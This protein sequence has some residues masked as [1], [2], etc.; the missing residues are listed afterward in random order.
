MTKPEAERRTAS[1]EVSLT[2][3]EKAE[4]VRAAKSEGL[5]TG[6]FM[7]VVALQSARGALT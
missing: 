6:T 5:L 4:I 7:R 1:V 2:P 3:A